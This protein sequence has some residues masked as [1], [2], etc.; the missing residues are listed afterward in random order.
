MDNQ[1]K[2]KLA[3]NAFNIIRDTPYRLDIASKDCSC[4]S[5]AKMLGEILIRLGFS[6]RVKIALFDWRDLPIPQDIANLGHKKFGISK[7]Y[8]IS[9]KDKTTEGW[10]KIDPTWDSGLKNIFPIAK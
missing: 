7:H 2:T 4:S 3:I 6:I 1:I 9:V 8:F 10:V 5:K